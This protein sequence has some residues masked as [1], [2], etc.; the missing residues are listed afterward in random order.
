MRVREQ[1]CDSTSG[2]RPQRHRHRNTAAQP[3]GASEGGNER[4]VL[5][6]ASRS[7]TLGTR[8]TLVRPVKREWLLMLRRRKM[9]TRNRKE[10]KLAD[11]PK[12]PAMFL[13]RALPDPLTD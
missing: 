12:Q 5:P 2:V 13:R 10:Q 3:A 9:K 4:T 1:K 8:Q 11:L 6:L 7:M